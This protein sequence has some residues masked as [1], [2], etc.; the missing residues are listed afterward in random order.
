MAECL[1]GAETEYAF[2]ALG[3]GSRQLPRD[4]LLG[5]LM[6]LAAAKLPHLADMFAGG[7]YLQNAARFY[8]DVGHHPEYSTPECSSP[9]EV[10]RHIRAGEQILT[11]LADGLARRHCGV[12]VMVFK[13]N[14]DYTSRATWGCHESYLH[15]AQPEVFP[16]QILPHLASR[17][18]YTGA[19]GFNPLSAG[20]EFTLSPRTWYLLSDMSGSSTGRRGVFHPKGE[21]LAAKGCFRLHL[22]CG[23]SLCSDL[24]MWLKNGTTSLVVAM[25]D[26]GLTPGA[27]VHLKSAVQA[28]RRFAADPTGRAS[29]R[30][31]AGRTLTALDIQRHY[32]ETAEAH[33][34]DPFMPPWADEVCQRWRAVLDRLEQG[35]DAV[36]DALDWAIKLAVFQNHARRRHVP[37]ASL[38]CWNGVLRQLA[39]SLHRA[40]RRQHLTPDLILNPGSPL[41]D[42]VKALTPV[43][44]SRGL[45]WS[46]VRNV[47]N[48]RSELFELDWRFG[49]LGP[50]GVFTS[51]DQ[52]GVLA[53]H[54][55]G[56]D[57]IAHAVTH[58]PVVGRARLRGECVRQFA[59][60]D[61]RYACDWQAIWDLKGHRRLDLTNPFQTERRWGPMEN[62]P[63]STERSRLLRELL[64]ATR[65]A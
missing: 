25:I 19:G 47:L 9:W 15:Y 54:V 61:D 28:M 34:H 21:S 42:T 2:T 24:G 22:L 1:S 26:A 29:V 50:K 8:I 38:E 39:H 62:D 14:V 6:T 57:N 18:V 51:L 53:H 27:A 41:A 35:P 30:S 55:P 45:E 20:I 4:E 16:E 23:E 31:A 3:L 11:D 17:L 52:A 5:Q 32:L 43:L 63:M 58:P 59:A 10:V 65:D 60:S 56:V 44:G 64:R 13:C 46:Q 33:V 49:Q 36:A 37:W 12:D 48:L 40:A 7:M